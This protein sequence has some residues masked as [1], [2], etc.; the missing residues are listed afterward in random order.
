GLKV[1]AKIDPNIYQIGIKVSKKEMDSINLHRHEFH[2][3]NWNY[4][5]K[6]N[7]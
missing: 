3:E 6:P 4:T 2:G 5:I 1:N 7:E